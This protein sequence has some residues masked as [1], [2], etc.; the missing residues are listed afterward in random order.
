MTYASYNLARFDLVSVRLAVCCAQTGSLT[1][2]ARENH[3]ALAAASRRIREIESAIGTE[4]FVRHA[5]GLL[6]TAAG[7]VFVKHGLSLLQTM[8]QI[9][10]E[11]ENLNR[12]IARHINL[13]SSSAAISEYLPPL[14]AQYSDQ[15]P[16]VLV[17][18][19]EQVSDSAVSALRDLRTDVAVFV[20]GPDTRGLV[21]K[22]FRSDELI[23]VTSS[24][25]RLSKSRKSISF[26]ELL[27]E[28]LICLSPGA[29]VLQKQ[30]QAALE[31]NKPLKIR[32][33]LRSFEAVCNMVAS[34][35]GIS[36]MPKVACLPMIKSL[37]LS[38]RPLSDE[39]SK[40]NLLVAVSQNE[41]DD[42]ILSFVDF[43]AH[44]SQNTNAK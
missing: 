28:E 5:K 12:G 21:A 14:L 4:L 27:D 8:K 6:P 34:N 18:V 16:Q 31:V 19:E 22:F 32:M 37:K 26:L 9:G 33:H 1:A 24:N 3:L 36:I 42:E 29:A 13:Y 23:V 39:W 2:A 25:H 11:I 20:E 40:R 17:D 38:W 44:S 15:R 43:L 10:C 35:L 30:Q 41:K 7:R